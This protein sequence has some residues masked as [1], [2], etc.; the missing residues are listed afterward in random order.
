MP[1]A[2]KPNIASLA[3]LVLTFTRLVRSLSGF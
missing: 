2:L 3:P 1:T